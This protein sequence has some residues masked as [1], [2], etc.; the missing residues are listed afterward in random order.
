MNKNQ[1]CEISRRHFLGSALLAGAVICFM[2]RRLFG[3]DG[4]PVTI[5]RDAAATAKINVTKLRGNVSMLEGSGGNIAVLTGRDGKLLVDAGITAS[6][7]RI[8]EALA[9]LSNDPV[10][11]L[12]NSHWHFDHTDGNEWLHSIGAEIIA[13]ENTRKHL[14]VTTRVED[15]NFTFPPAPSGA[16]PTKLFDSEQT[17]HLN[18]SPIALKKY[19]PAHTDSDISVE[20]TDADIVHVADTF[21]NGHFPFIDYSTGGSIDGMIR[22]AETN[23]AKVT[24]KTIVVPGHGPIGNKSQLIEFRD[25]LV[26]VREKVADLKN[27]GKSLDEV[28]AA[29][30]T[31][32]YDAKWGGFVIDGNF[33]TRLVY[34]G[35]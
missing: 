22:A 31:A 29:K 24:D 13:H 9:S 35:V 32:N 4:S 19:S 14:S 28:V 25:M 18:G 7:P 15:W 26:S 1:A 30:P 11:H 23:V 27:Q 10:K 21:W 2:P 6:R 3:V 8:T 16:L 33:F 20:F 17:L 34:A 5:I 12:I